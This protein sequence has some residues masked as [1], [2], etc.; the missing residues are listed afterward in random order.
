MSAL[1]RLEQTGARL[2]SGYR[3]FWNSGVI[4]RA[5]EHT[6]PPERLLWTMAAN[7]EWVSPTPGR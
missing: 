7:M 1:R 2:T 4:G 6:G 5:T 3:F